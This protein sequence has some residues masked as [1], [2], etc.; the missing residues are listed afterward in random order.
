M[1]NQKNRETKQKKQQQQSG[2]DTVTH[3]VFTYVTHSKTKKFMHNLEFFMHKEKN[4][5]V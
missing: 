4:E 3:N 2:L 1:P 5:T